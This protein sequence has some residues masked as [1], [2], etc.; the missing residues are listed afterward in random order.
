[1]LILNLRKGGVLVSEEVKL[2]MDIQMMEVV[3]EMT[4]ESVN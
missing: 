4:T 3:E 2:T 1:M